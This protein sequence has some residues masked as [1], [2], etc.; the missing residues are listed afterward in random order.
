MIVGDSAA[1][2]I[3]SDILQAFPKIGQPALGF[4]VIHLG[5]RMFG[6]KAPDASMLGNSLLAVDNRLQRRGKHC[7]PLLADI[8][9]TR[10]AEAYLDAIYADTPRTDYCG[11]SRQAFIDT[12]SSHHVVWAPDGDEA[13][14]DGSHVLHFDVG[15]RVRLVAFVNTESRADLPASIRQ[16]WLEAE[17]FYAVLWRWKERFMAE[18]T[19]RLEQEPRPA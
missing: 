8:E 2:A 7:A 11:L 17:V 1:F 4:F 6:V 13:F 19:R 9:A 5:G 14:D 15:E 10:L 16:I 3:E 18:W 12:L